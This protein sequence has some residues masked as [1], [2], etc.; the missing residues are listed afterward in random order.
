MLQ[1][2]NDFVIVALSHFS[3]VALISKEDKVINYY[4]KSEIFKQKSIKKITL[5]MKYA[6]RMTLF[7]F[8]TR[9]IYYI[10]TK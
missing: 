8:A 1:C 2:D 4:Q 5:V 10:H 9:K 6:E 3:I 7:Y